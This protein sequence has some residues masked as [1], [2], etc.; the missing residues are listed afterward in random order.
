MD[1]VVIGRAPS[2]QLAKVIIETL[3]SEGIEAESRMGSA[4]TV[5]I[6]VSPSQ[7]DAAREILGFLKSAI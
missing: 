4:G 2:R 5:E 3:A 1:Q 7:A 6:L